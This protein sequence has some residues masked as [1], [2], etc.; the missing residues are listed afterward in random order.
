MFVWE[1]LQV[2]NKNF[3]PYFQ[4]VSLVGLPLTS[5]KR[6][7][8]SGISLSM[9]PHSK[10]KFFLLGVEFFSL[11][12]GGSVSLGPDYNTLFLFYKNVFHKNIEAEI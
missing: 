12:S 8:F 2:V 4:R 7:H 10:E 11:S 1:Y 3:S 6:G 9:F 5:K